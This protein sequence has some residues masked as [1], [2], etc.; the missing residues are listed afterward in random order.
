MGNHQNLKKQT[1]FTLIELSITLV[2]IAILATMMAPSFSELVQNTRLTS[3]ANLLVGSLSYARTKAISR[4][5]PVCIC[6]SNNST[7]CTDTPWNQGWIVFT[8]SEA[9][10]EVDADDKVLLVQQELP[11]GI[12][13]TLD[14]TDIQFQP[15]GLFTSYCSDC[16]GL[17][18]VTGKSHTEIP[19]VIR[20]LQALVPEAIASN[21][22]GGNDNG[23]NDNG[24]NDN[25][26]NDNGGNDNG[27]NDNGG[28][29]NGG[30]DNG[31]NDNGGND[32]DSNDNGGNDNGGND[33]GGNDNGGN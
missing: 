23:G 31:G 8:D 15:T 4:G 24:G 27:G 2:I 21:D 7:N 12:T 30:N 28:N 13:L 22:N 1:A 29:D 26:S 16:N 17:S 3:N 20:L 14:K 19:W 25:D 6:A 5:S 18:P 10:C 33:N 32:N 11:G 9:A